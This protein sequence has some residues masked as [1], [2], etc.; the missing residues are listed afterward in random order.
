M[1]NYYSGYI[2]FSLS[3]KI[4]IE[5]VSDFLKIRNLYFLTENKIFTKDI[6]SKQFIDSGFF[7]YE[8]FDDIVVDHIYVLYWNAETNGYIKLMPNQDYI[9]DF[10][11]EI[12]NYG[13]KYDFCS[14]YISININT[15]HFFTRGKDPDNLIDLIYNLLC[16]YIDFDKDGY[17][18]DTN[19]S[20]YCIGKIQ[21]EDQ[22]YL[23]YY[24]PTKGRYEYLREL[25]S[26][27]FCGECELF[28]LDAFC[29]NYKFCKRAYELGLNKGDN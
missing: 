21:D 27:G 14:A 4:P 26:E 1:G 3:N 25:R 24:Y 23:K 18:K 19:P 9:T 8:N 22:T 15:K 6:F 17:N 16:S 12:E 2:D 11:K 13:I 28:E 29:K 20:K 10:P 5:L 7:D